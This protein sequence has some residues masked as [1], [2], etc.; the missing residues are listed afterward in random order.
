MAVNSKLEG[1]APRNLEEAIQEINKIKAYLR[2]GIPPIDIL[3][4]STD[5]QVNLG[6]PANRFH[7]IFANFISLGDV[8]ISGQDLIN[9]RG[10]GQLILTHA[11]TGN[12]IDLRSSGMVPPGATQAIISGRS[13]TNGAGGGGG[14][15]ANTAYTTNVGNNYATAG[16]GGGGGS[17]TAEYV[18]IAI[19]IG[20]DDIISAVVGAGGSGGAGGSVAVNGSNGSAGGITQLTVGSMVFSFPP[21][22]MGQGGGRGGSGNI[23]STTTPGTGTG[24][25]AVPGSTSYFPQGGGGGYGGVTGGQ[26]GGG[27]RISNSRGTIESEGLAGGTGGMGSQGSESTGGNG[28]NGRFFLPGSFTSSGPNRADATAGTDGSNGVDGSMTILFA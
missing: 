28:G 23:Y 20:Q 1:D 18:Q 11:I 17:S 10:Q 3:G 22:T 15:G 14:G 27:G 7:E 25:S 21:A 16:G 4:S 24:E 2:G 13:G 6:G 26:N 19:L 5:G 9:L 8:R 12:G